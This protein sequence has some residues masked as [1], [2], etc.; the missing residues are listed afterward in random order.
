M[1]I[2]Q[3]ILFVFIIMMMGCPVRAEIISVIANPNVTESTI[4]KSSIQRIYLGKKTR[5]DNNLK[6]NPA[7]LSKGL[8]HDQFIKNYVNKSI[9]QFITFWKKAVFTGRGLP[10]K[11]FEN[12]SD[13][14]KYVADTPGAIGYVSVSKNISGVK[15]L[16]VK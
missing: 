4:D 12:E 6:I 8:T 14:I 13:L 2:K 7:M 11:S 9:P 5:W 15:I 10:P 1:K 3:F 16:N